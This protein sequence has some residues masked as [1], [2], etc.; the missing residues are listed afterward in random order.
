MSIHFAGFNRPLIPRFQVVLYSLEPPEACARFLG[1]G[2]V[3]GD[4]LFGEE[5]GWDALTPLRR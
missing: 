2:F 1:E 4:P 5:D 3:E